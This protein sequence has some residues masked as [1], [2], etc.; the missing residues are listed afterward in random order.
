[1]NGYLSAHPTNER[2]CTSTRRNREA[3]QA[4]PPLDERRPEVCSVLWILRD[5]YDAFTRPQAA[6]SD[7]LTRQSW[8]EL[9]EWVQRLEVDLE[10][11]RGCEPG[12]T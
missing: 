5:D 7:R 9:Q 1:M 3:P 11:A 10:S 6:D 2:A 4:S 8:R 12:H